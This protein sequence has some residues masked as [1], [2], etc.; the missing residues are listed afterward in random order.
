MAGRD[1]LHTPGASPSAAEPP[2]EVEP[3]GGAS[4]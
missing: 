4:P 1:I 3:P 2:G